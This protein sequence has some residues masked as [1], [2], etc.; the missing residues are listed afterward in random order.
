[1]NKFLIN[2]I[3]TAFPNDSSN[4]TSHND[5]IDKADFSIFE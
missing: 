2:K 5:V 4:I 1:M 3:L